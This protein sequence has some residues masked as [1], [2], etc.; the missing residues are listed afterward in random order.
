MTRPRTVL[1]QVLPF[2]LAI[3][4][5]LTPVPAG[6][7]PPAWHLFA[8][9]ASAIASVLLGSFPLLTSALLAVAA[10]VLTGTVSP[11]KAFAGF[12][13]G[14]VLLVVIAFLVAIAVVKS[15]LGRR[16]SLFMVSL[17][18]QSS[19]GLAYSIVITDALIAPGFPSNTAR[20]GVLFPIVLSVASG[21]GS[22]PEEPEGRKLGGY[23]MF[24][25]M[26]SLAVSS[27][28]WMT[29]TSANPLGVQ[30]VREFGVAISFGKWLVVAAVP[31]LTALL[32]LPWL[33]ARIFPP[34]IGR[35]PEAPVAA[36]KE[37]A[38]LGSLKRDE[39]ITA[40][41]FAFMVLGWVFGDLLQLN[42]TSVAFAGLGMLLMSN[43]LK[44]TDIAEH[45]EALDT[46]MWL[47]VLFALSGQLNE[48]GFMGYVGQRLASYI[49]GLSWPMTYV[50]LIVLYVLIHYMF[51][52]QTSQVLALL[53]VFL[54][55]GVR[56]G[57]PAPL[58]AFALLFASSYFSVITPQGG[59]QN[60][61]FVSSGY[62]TQPEL[63]RLG[64]F[65]TLFFLAVFL[66]IGTPWI[67]LVS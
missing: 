11:A 56:G 60:V 18:G 46:F 23:L 30:V 39:W 47:A 66:I 55:V 1:K 14:S 25:G 49:V 41:I 37:L 33:V 31:A 50:I 53:G 65:V 19:L 64:L 22:R 27:A 28:L 48:L 3:G 58:M 7:T 54:D 38:A 34:G 63:Y 15:G 26:A 16:I 36:R 32:L 10:A 62:L 24:C 42:S 51:V 44:L 6:L 2:A 40:G 17:F 20:G 5:W 13:N 57:V 8:V 35:T 43:V 9:F 29:A 59:S 4:I 45:G 21:S 12:A 61:I 52:S 67:L